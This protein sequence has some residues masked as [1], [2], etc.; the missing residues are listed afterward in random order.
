MQIDPAASTGSVSRGL[1]DTTADTLGNGLRG[2][3]VSKVRQPNRGSSTRIEL[4]MALPGL[5]IL[6][7]FFEPQAIAPPLAIAFHASPSQIGVTVNATLS[8]MAVAGILT[9]AFGDRISRKPVTVGALLLLSVP[10]M[11]VA[12]A[13]SVVV[14]G[15]LRTAQG[16]LMCR[17]IARQGRLRRSIRKLNGRANRGIVIKVRNFCCLVAGICCG[18]RGAGIATPLFRSTLFSGNARDEL[19]CHR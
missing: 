14:F 10:T 6:M 7:D 3:A 12:L 8:G 9:G 17:A 13:P 19:L 11:L 4:L 1:T 16:L 18:N 2:D 5:L 15:L